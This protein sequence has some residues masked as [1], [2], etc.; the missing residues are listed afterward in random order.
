MNFPEFHRFMLQEY[1]EYSPR[2]QWLADTVLRP[3]IDRVLP[4]IG[5]AQE[6]GVLPKVEPIILHY[7]MISLTSTLSTFGSEMLA[8]NK[9]SA[10]DPA[11]I[12][13][14]WSTVEALLFGVRAG[15]PRTS[16]P[17]PGDAEKILPRQTSQAN[18]KRPI[19]KRAV[20]S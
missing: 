20:R 5:E 6:E 13:S 7:L 1:L 10:S 9:L 3:L 17:N 8:T 16:K 14:Y 2:L 12:E 19:T 11:V 4:Q 15:A 18:N